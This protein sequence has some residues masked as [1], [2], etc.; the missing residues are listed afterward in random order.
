MVG[1]FCLQ[2]GSDSEAHVFR[3]RREKYPPD[4]DISTEYN[5]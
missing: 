1:D 4:P 3:G 5:T 2:I